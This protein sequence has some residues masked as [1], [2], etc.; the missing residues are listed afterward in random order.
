M[1]KMRTNERVCKTEIKA[2]KKELRRLGTRNAKLIAMVKLLVKRTDCVA[3]VRI[4]GAMPKG[5]KALANIEEDND[6]Q[7][8]L[9]VVRKHSELSIIKKLLNKIIADLKTEYTSFQKKV[10]RITCTHR[11]NSRALSERQF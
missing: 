6:A 1:L 11:A 7:V 5:C 10:N 3:A 4:G 8:L 2:G 9:Q